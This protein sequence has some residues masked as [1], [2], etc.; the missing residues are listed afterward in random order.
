MN[1]SWFGLLPLFL[2]DKEA[3]LSA[4]RDVGDWGTDGKV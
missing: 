4:E 1:S 3:H 2:A